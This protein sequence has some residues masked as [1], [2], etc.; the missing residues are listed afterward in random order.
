MADARSNNNRKKRERYKEEEAREKWLTGK[1]CT[2]AFL[3]NC[4]YRDSELMNIV[5]R[6]HYHCYQLIDY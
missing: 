5:Q 6:E 2:V 4:N 3:T 1:N